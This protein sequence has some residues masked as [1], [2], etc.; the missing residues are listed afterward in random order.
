M[1]EDLKRKF[2]DRVLRY[3]S[4]RIDI[5]SSKT[6]AII[7]L[8]GIGSPL[9]VWLARAG[10]GSL[11]LVDGDII[12]EHNL[13]RYEGVTIEDVGEFKVYSLMNYILKIRPW[14][15]VIAF[16]YFLNEIIYR[17]IEVD[18]HD[19]SCKIFL[20]IINK[21]DLMIVAVDSNWARFWASWLA[22]QY[23]IPY[24]DIA[25]DKSGIIGICF[26]PEPRKGPCRICMFN[27]RDLGMDELG[28]NFTVSCPNT[29]M[30]LKIRNWG[31]GEKTF[32]FICGSEKYS[33]AERIYEGDKVVKIRFKCPS[34]G[35]IHEVS[36]PKDPVPAVIE[37]SRRAALESF[38][39]IIDFL[40][41]NKIPSW[42][43]K[44]VKRDL[45]ETFKIPISESHKDLHKCLWRKC[46]E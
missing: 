3:N 34:C 13:E 12:E 20:D 6:V 11:I 18:W 30:C 45:R 5:L 35:Q 14:L 17:C 28:Y 39:I 40:V 25:F 33:E 37:I 43:Y 21:I 16:P 2:F 19:K 41:E 46:D 27:E 29:G 15:K 10:I 31:R 42:N 9:A 22:I 7:G 24:I 4:R 8:G 26:F 38:E 23:N 32:V 1:R 44:I 36:T